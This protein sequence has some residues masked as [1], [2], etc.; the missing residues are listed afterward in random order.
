MLDLDK[1]SLLPYSFYSRDTITVAKEL[2]GKY[3]VYNNGREI[4]AGRVVETEAYLGKEDPACHSARGRDKRNEV[5]FG[6]AG[7][8]YIYL[9]YGIHLCFNVT[10]GPPHKP[11]AVLI[12]ALESV[13]GIEIMR[14]NRGKDDIFNLCSGPGKLVQAM[15][16]GMELNGT[17][18]VEGPIR[19]YAK[20]CKENFDIVTTTRIGIS[21]AADWPLRFYVA[22][23]RFVSK[24]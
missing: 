14:K 15:G 10:T 16:F 12:R 22:Q 7:Y 9:I 20:N 19:F 4:V 1:L 6:P 21:K 11:E 13:L 23:S 8:A 5:M 24:R 18:V 2:L 3:M 17:S